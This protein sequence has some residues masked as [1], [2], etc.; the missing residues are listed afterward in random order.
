MSAHLA[1]SGVSEGL[2]WNIRA[3]T[4]ETTAVA[5]DVPVPLK[6]ESPTRAD[7]WVTSMRD[8]GSR[9]DTMEIPG[10]TTSGLA[11]PSWVGPSEE[12]GAT[13]SS[14][15]LEVCSVSSAPT[16]TT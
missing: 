10:A 15:T 1:W 14:E 7:G 8:P 12:N 2:A 5:C 3:A 13:W 16:V 4:P 6:Y 9:S 11:N